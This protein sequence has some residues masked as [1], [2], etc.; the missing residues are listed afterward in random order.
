MLEDSLRSWNPWWAEKN[1]PAE[2]L[3]TFRHRLDELIELLQVDHVKDV[4]GVRRCGKTTVMHQ[5]VD[6][7]L[8]EE[9]MAPGEIALLNFD[10]PVIHETEFGEL[11][12]SLAALH[13]ETRILLL[14]EIQER[15]GWQRWVRSLY[16]TGAY[17]QILL[18]GSSSS[19]LEGELGRVLSGRHVTVRMFPFSFK[20]YLTHKEWEGIE[21]PGPLDP[22][23]VSAR[24]RE[25][26]H[27][28]RSYL[29]EGGF[30]E[31]VGQGGSVRKRLLTTLFQDIVA[32]DVVGRHG[33]RPAI[34]KKLANVL[35]SNAG[36]PFTYRR[37][38]N[39]TGMATDTVTKYLGHLTEAFL[40][41]ELPPFSHKVQER[42]RGPRKFYAIDPGL[43][44]TVGSSP[45]EDRGPLLEMAV[46]LHLW[47]QGHSIYHWRDSDQR[48]IDIV[49][50]GD[51]TVEC[52][53]QICHDP[54]GT[55]TLDRE[56]AALSSGMEELRTDEGRIVSWNTDDRVDVDGQEV[57]IIPAWKLL[58]DLEPIPP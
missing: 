6:H 30:P 38:A 42:Y 40:F 43:A 9:Q 2:L 20:E 45:T 51:G 24:K 41:R 15:E 31:A 32:R 26:L 56:T 5:L 37:L 19:L 54:T 29:Q 49:V 10:D 12:D 16:D 27:H 52:L 47:R 57:P 4:V 3:G 39:A 13:P 25:I 17:D 23:I 1:V 22:D 34:A 46:V 44:S 18:S 55:A 7:L 35:I 53:L 48:E 28:L 36:S 21:G 8:E 33:A 50:E 58:L 11:L 14:D